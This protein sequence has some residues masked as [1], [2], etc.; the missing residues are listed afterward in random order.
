MWHLK[1]ARKPQVTELI[2]TP[3]DE[4][5]VLQ[6]QG[7]EAQPALRMGAF[8]QL[9]RPGQRDRVGIQQKGPKQQVEQEKRGG[10]QHLSS[11]PPITTKLP[12]LPS[13]KT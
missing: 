9:Q 2:W 6:S 3:K 8:R 12:P 11:Q 13:R 4:F 7:I 5:N 10:K 1:T